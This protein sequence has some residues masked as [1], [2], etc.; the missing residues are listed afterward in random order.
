MAQAGA[1]LHHGGAGRATAL[2][3]RQPMRSTALLAGQSMQ[4][5]LI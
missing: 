3:A 1:N 5:R 4:G 2:L